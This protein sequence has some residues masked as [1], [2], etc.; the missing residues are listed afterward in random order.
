MHLHDAGHMNKMAAIPVYG[1][2]PLKN[3]LSR[4]QWTNSD[5]TWYVAF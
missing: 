2:N 4:N 3:L 1:K 5:E